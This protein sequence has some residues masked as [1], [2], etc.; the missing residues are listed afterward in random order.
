MLSK[1]FC[2]QRQTLKD[3]RIEENLRP[4]RDF[5]SSAQRFRGTTDTDA[6]LLVVRSKPPALEFSTRV[7]SLSHIRLF[8]FLSYTAT[9][10]REI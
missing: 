3:F 1:Y 2:C 5:F 7:S 10:S 6:E 8:L 9:Y 4:S